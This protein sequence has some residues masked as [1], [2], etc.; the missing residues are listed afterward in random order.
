M[1]RVLNKVPPSGI[2]EFFDIAASMKDVISLGIG[3][4]DFV[5]PWNV[6]ESAI[7]SLERGYTHYTSNKGIPELRE[8]ISGYLK[9]EFK[10]KY[11]PDNI[12]VTVGVSEA[13]D[14][15]LRTILNPGDEIIIPE[16]CFVSYKPLAMLAG[17]VPVTL[18]TSA[19]DNF[20][21]LAEDLRKKVTEKTKALLINYPNNPTGAVLK[22]GD[23]K[24][25]ADIALENGIYI[26]SDEI[27]AELTYGQEHASFAS[28]PELK[29][30][31]VFLHGVS[32][33]FA[34]TGFRVGYAAAPPEIISGM[35][36]IHQ[37]CIMSAPTVS[38][39]AALEAMKDSAKDVKSMAHE[40]NERRRLIVDGFNKM[41]L[42]CF[43]PKGAFYCFPSIAKTKLSS[44]D[45]SKRLI[46]KQKVAAVPGTAFGESGE[47]HIRCSYAASL[48][49]IEE[50]LLR[51]EKFVK[52]L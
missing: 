39:Y 30:R 19:K 2:R 50:A 37:Y 51:I 1:N 9:K 26:I 27:Y 14:L 41:G 35:A 47:G 7:T 46:R 49:D 48:E 18:E 34:M 6:R 45:F 15:A 52:G 16:P 33:A 31:L 42:G 24:K 20:R 38:Q 40:Y 28:I 44:Y 36:K 3:E 17:A 11:S 4:P 22:K 12:L 5:S 29:K 8:A 10:G 43:E 25:I 23:V 32:K 13:I 21:V